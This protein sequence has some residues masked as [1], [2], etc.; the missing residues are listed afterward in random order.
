MAE[1]RPIAAV[2]TCSDARV[3]PARTFDLPA[4]SLFVIRVAG[5]TATEE[6]VASLSYAVEH[7][8]VPTVVV[9]GHSH[10]GA[11]TAA[12]SGSADPSIEAV[13]APIRPPVAAARCTD[14]DCAVAA[15]VRSTV[16]AITNGDS[17]LGTAVRAGRVAVHGAVLDLADQTIDPL[18]PTDQPPRRHAT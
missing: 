17:P 11:V 12:M 9:L 1:H 18:P 16:T 4:G 10:C 3:S 5:N 7:L 15:N 6:A 13:L 14:V 8:G 2:L